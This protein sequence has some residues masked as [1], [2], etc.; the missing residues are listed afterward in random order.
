MQ[1]TYPTRIEARHGA[2]LT[3]EEIFS[4]ARARETALARLLMVYISTGLGFMLLPGTFLGVW[5]LISISTRHAAETV[6]RPWIQAHGHAQ[7]F[8]WV[9]CFILGIGFHSLPKLRRS[10]AFAL[11]TA[12]TCW[13][14]WT[15]GVALRWLADVYRWH[16]RVLLPASALLE[17]AAFVL[18]FRAVSAHKPASPGPRRGFETWTMVVI[19]ATIG[20]L[21]TLLANLAGAVYLALRGTDPAFPPAFDLRFLI[22]S[23]WGFLVPFVWGF[24]AKWMPVFLGLKPPRARLLQLA[25]GLN[26]VGVVVALAGFVGGATVV[27]VATAVMAPLALRM[28]ERAQQPPKTRGVHASMPAFVRA[29]YGWL[30]VAAA[31]GAWAAQV[32]SANGIWGASRHALTVGFVAVMIF[33]VGQRILPAFSGMRLLFSTR[34]MFVCLALL[35][36]GCALRVSCELLAYQGYA[37]GA[38][39]WLPVSAVIELAAVTVFAINI[40]ATFA[41]R[42]T[43]A[44]AGNTV[45]L[46]QPS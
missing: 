46:V 22:L 1:R 9:G 32:E 16:W 43:G 35:S 3:P 7:I 8:G 31:L 23:T 10:D 18:F 11:W 4:I 20:L 37:A 26:A 21:L 44:G 40:A 30:I 13:A 42:P 2:P 5:N 28:F 24:S 6:S 33:S 38:W 17:I 41:S 45:T 25:F 29:A 15:T 19:G 27:F 14:M 12:W 39:R 34:L 36:V